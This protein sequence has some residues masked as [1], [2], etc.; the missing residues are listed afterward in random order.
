MKQTNKRWN[1]SREWWNGIYSSLHTAVPVSPHPHAHCQWHCPTQ[2]YCSFWFSVLTP[3]RMHIPPAG[4]SWLLEWHWGCG[5]NTLLGTYKI[6]KEMD[7]YARKHQG[8]RWRMEEAKGEYIIGPSHYK[9]SSEKHGYRWLNRHFK[10][11]RCLWYWK[12][13]RSCQWTW[14]SIPTTRNWGE[15]WWGMLSLVK[16]YLRSWMAFQVVPVRIIS[17]P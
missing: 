3:H 13:E 16:L 9:A 17:V 6:S 7:P 11:S 5:A 1:A 15:T 4:W 12:C 10:E 2:R 14:S 8:S